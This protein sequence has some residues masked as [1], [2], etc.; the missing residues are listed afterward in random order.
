MTAWEAITVAAVASTTS[1]IRAQSG[2]SRKNG[3]RRFAVVLEDQRALAEVAQRAGGEDQE[4][5]AHRDRPAAEVAHVGVERLGAGDREHDRGQ[6]EEREVE[7]AGQEPDGVR[8]GEGPRIS[9][10]L[11]MP[12]M[13]QA[14]IATNQTIMTGPKNRPTAAVP[15]RCTGNSRR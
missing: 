12:Q 4:E 1:G 15:N 8:R 13:P 11:V 6:R 5:P 14:P 2:A 3:A 7:V 10:S 9:G